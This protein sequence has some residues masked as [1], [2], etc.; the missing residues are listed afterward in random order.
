MCLPPPCIGVCNPCICE[1]D[2]TCVSDE[3]AMKL[4]RMEPPHRKINAPL[5]RDEGSILQTCM[6]LHDLHCVT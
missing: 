1:C 3:E 4:I 6:I 5:V 2:P